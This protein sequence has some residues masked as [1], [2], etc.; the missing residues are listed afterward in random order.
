MQVPEIEPVEEEVPEPRIKEHKDFK[1]PMQRHNSMHSERKSTQLQ[2][3]ASSAN[4]IERLGSMMSSTCQSATMRTISK[5]ERV[6]KMREIKKFFDCFFK[7]IKE[8]AS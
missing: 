5:K 4:R 7:E 6:A 8:L 3:Q 1:E 2:L